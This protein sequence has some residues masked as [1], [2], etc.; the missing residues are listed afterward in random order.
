MIDA[1]GFPKGFLG[2]DAYFSAARVVSVASFGLP[3]GRLP[4]KATLLLSAR[5][6]L[7]E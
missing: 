1:T 4:Y 3:N 2:I 6:D 7:P 5:L